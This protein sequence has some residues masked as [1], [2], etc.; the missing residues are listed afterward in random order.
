MAT[1]STPKKL[2]ILEDQVLVRKLI[3]RQT[4][5][6]SRHAVT[7]DEFSDPHQALERCRE[8]H[9]DLIMTDIGIPGMNG[10][11]FIGELA[12][13]GY[14]GALL[15]I[16][17]MDKKT[18]TTINDMARRMGLSPVRFLSKPYSTDQFIETLNHLLHKLESDNK[19]AHTA[20][21]VLPELLS[22]RFELVFERICAT[23][24]TDIKGYSVQGL[25]T[26]NGVEL[27]LEQAYQ[28]LHPVERADNGILSI[29]QERIS[30]YL[31]TTQH[32]D[33][34]FNIPVPTYF[35][36]EEQFSHRWHTH[37]RQQ[38]ITPARVG[39][40]LTGTQFHPDSIRFVQ[41]LVQLKYLGYPLIARQFTEGNLS[42]SQL[43][44]LPFDRASLSIDSLKYLHSFNHK[45]HFH[46]FLGLCGLQPHHVIITGIDHEHD[47]TTL[48]T[49][50]LTHYQ[51]RHHA[52]TVSESKLQQQLGLPVDSTPAQTMPLQEQE[53]SS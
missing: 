50:G 33:L 49:L 27:T 43:L 48:H 52:G 20:E 35:L 40:E 8:R 31:K 36:V 41:N 16:S 44:T 1:D 14:T 28:A 4:Q 17:G 38:R 19:P 12:N 9:Y 25:T 15:V 32:P 18:L 21:Q 37:F 3:A 46:G 10:I 26:H 34:V 47:L 42:I 13:Q 5:F 30:R 6:F 2:L 7:I 29:C 11:E 39:I 24:S 51:G 22:G 45:D 23:N 53:V